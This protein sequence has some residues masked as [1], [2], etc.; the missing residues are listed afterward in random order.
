MCD[1]P[2]AILRTGNKACMGIGEMD[3]AESAQGVR[4]KDAVI[5]QKEDIVRG[6]NQL[7]A[8]ILNRRNS[9]PTRVDAELLAR[10]GDVALD[11]KLFAELG[12]LNEVACG[13]IEVGLTVDK[14]QQ[15]GPLAVAL[16]HFQGGEDFQQML[17][18]ADGENDCRCWQR[19]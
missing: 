1:P 6:L 4:S 11:T 17:L 18:T 2:P 9:P 13:E 8:S 19:K 5:F 3:C 16:E 12:V 7:T 15:A 10:A 14:C